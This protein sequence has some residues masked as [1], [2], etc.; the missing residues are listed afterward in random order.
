MELT[1]AHDR[2]AWANMSK[3][4][5]REYWTGL[6]EEEQR[7]AVLRNRGLSASDAGEFAA[8]W[9]S[10]PETEFYTCRRC[11]RFLIDHDTGRVEPHRLLLVAMIPEDGAYVVC[12]ECDPLPITFRQRLARVICAGLVPREVNPE[13]A[14]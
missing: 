13:P 1:E 3:E 6:T 10:F 4:E 9:P 7:A 12:E 2:D 14:D 8:G 11:R 5:R